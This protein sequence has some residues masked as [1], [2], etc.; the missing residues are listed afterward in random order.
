MKPIAQLLQA[1]QSGALTSRAL[2]EQYLAAA[3]EGEGPRVYLQLDPAK[4]RRA[5]DSRDRAYKAGIQGKPLLGLPISVKDLCDVIDEVTTAGSIVLKDAPPA[6]EDAPIIRRLRSA[7]AIPFGRTNMTEFAFSGL[8]INPHYGAPRNPYDRRPDGSGRIPGGSSSGAAV[9]VTDNMA[10]AA[11]GSDT[12]GSIRIPAALCGLT[13]F[14]PTKRRVPTTGAYPLSQTLDSLGPLAP[15]VACC[16]LLDAIFAGESPRTLAPKPISQLRLGVL[17]GYVLEGLDAP[18]S[19]AFQSALT[20]LS[21]AGARLE[22]LHFDELP[23][24]PKAN[25]KGSIPTYE[26]YA[27]H[28]DMLAAHGDQY[29]PIVRTRLS[30][31]TKMTPTDFHDLLTARDRIIAAAT[32]AFTGYDAILLPTIACIAPRIADC[33]ASLD[34]WLAANALILRNPS[35]FNFLDGCG[36]TLPIHRPSEAPVGLMVMHLAGHDHDI[37]NIGATLEPI[38][39]QAGHAILT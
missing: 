34:A 2:V 25:A 27:W 32:S 23:N 16:A 5:A 14:K 26:G 7:G 8:G 1:M 17:Q 20:A 11:I 37:L 29:D 4:V 35:V 30:L 36:L 9:S 31:A 12:G 13:G 6:T 19:T 18:V 3:S 15:T 10:A 38:L 39:K 24:I 33:E 22:D 28:K 21:Q